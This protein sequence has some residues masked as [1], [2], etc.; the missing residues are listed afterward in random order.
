MDLAYGGP[1]PNRGQIKMLKKLR[2]MV[3]LSGTAIVASAQTPNTPI[4]SGS[5]VFIIC[6][7]CTP[8]A[9]QLGKKLN[10]PISHV[11]MMLSHPIEENLVITLTSVAGNNGTSSLAVTVKKF[12]ALTAM[13]SSYDVSANKYNLSYDFTSQSPD[14]ATLVFSQHLTTP[15]VVSAV[16]ISI[17]CPQPPGRLQT[18][19]H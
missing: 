4:P 18:V 7:D 3:L 8:Q 6:N 19:N 9:G 5:K 12:G 16:I 14:E 13:K 1:N 2:T 15:E 10:E 11:W 17:I